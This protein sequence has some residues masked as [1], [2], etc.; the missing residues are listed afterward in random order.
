MIKLIASDVDG[1][2]VPEGTSTVNPQLIQQIRKIRQQ[3]IRFVAASGRQYSAILTALGEL[4]DEI[5]FIA[6][7]GAYIIEHNRPLFTSAFAPE[8]WKDMVGFVHEQF[9]ADIMM[10]SVE[11]TFSDSRSKDFYQMLLEGY[12]LDLDPV[13]DLTALDVQVTKVGIYLYDKNPIQA[14]RVSKE[15]YGGLSNILV[16]GECWMDYVPT[17]AD[18]GLALSKI[19]EHFGISMEETMAFGDN[20]N[21]IGLLKRAGES[22][23]VSNARAEVKTAAVHV[24]DEGADNDGVLHILQ[25]F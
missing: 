22:Y 19:Q 8:L 24:M 17:D 3:G 7:N 16:S 11:G 1:T 21:D 14:A 6:D 4:R 9:H 23:A 25:K 2:L 12:G 5:I 20:N 10:S 15:K 18:K 13:P